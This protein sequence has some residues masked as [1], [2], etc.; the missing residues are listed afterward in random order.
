M[1][2]LFTTELLPASDRIDAWQWNAQQICGDCRI[3]LPK[4]SFHGCIEVRH[5]GGFPLTR[6]SSS[7]LAFW[8]SPFNTVNAETRSCIVITQLAGARMYS[9]NGSEVVLRPGDST[10]IDSAV[11]WS[12]ACKTD[13]VRLYFRV[14]RWIMEQKTQIQEIP[15]S[16]RIS[17]ASALGAALSH[18][19]QSL[20]E[21]AEWMKQSEIAAVLDHYFETLSACFGYGDDRFVPGAELT[22]RILEFIDDHISEPTL[23]P[24]EIAVA[25][26]I[27]VRHLHRVFS[28]TGKT[29]SDFIRERR[30]DQ[31]R[32]DL[33]NPRYQERTITE[34]AFLRGFSDAAHFSHS[35]R[36]HFGVC[37]RDFRTQI[38]SHGSDG[39]G[40]ERG[41]HGRDIPGARDPGP[42]CSMLS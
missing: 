22:R 2:R 14:P 35:F 4:A 11:P 1:S 29:V 24:V 7:S 17:G 27:S 33:I 5:V 41:H 20:F 23:S 30:L 15:T 19:S 26:G 37:A 21:E 3:R 8:K 18:L 10:V 9:Q 16:R 28:A 12:S 38:A 42:D 6:F 13:C 34:I 32:Q 39:F 36:K 25:I 40:C 31:C